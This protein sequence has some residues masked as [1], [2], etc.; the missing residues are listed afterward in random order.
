MMSVSEGDSDGKEV[1]LLPNTRMSLLAPISHHAMG[2][3]RENFLSWASTGKHLG[4]DGCLMERISIFLYRWPHPGF[5]GGT[6]KVSDMPM[7]SLKWQSWGS[8]PEPMRLNPR[9][10]RLLCTV[11]LSLKVAPRED[12]VP[13]C[14]EAVVASICRVL[15]TFLNLSQ[16]QTFWL[17]SSSLK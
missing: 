17:P 8:D 12:D 13:L 3:R 1:E 9:L 7:F 4:L 15:Y 16:R 11:D 5:I 10:F 2:Y 6:W 14:L